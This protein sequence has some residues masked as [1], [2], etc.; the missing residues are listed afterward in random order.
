ML[1]VM[2]DACQVPVWLVHHQLEEPICLMAD[3]AE[4]TVQS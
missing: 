3:V 1:H 4:L 2:H